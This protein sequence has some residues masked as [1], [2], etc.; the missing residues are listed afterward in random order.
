MSASKRRG[1]RYEV[2]SETQ[3]SDNVGAQGRCWYRKVF[4]LKKEKVLSFFPGLMSMGSVGRGEKNYSKN[5]FERSSS[6]L[7]RQ[8][9][10][11]K[12]RTCRQ[13]STFSLLRHGGN[14]VA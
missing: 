3:R 8:L 12:L 13:I 10:G 4:F 2:Q 5:R 11:P 14:K 9:A 7:Y 1:C 6:Q